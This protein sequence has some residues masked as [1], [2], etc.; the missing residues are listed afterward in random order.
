MHTWSIIISVLALSAAT[1]AY[2]ASNRFDQPTTVVAR[3]Q[4]TG[5]NISPEMVELLKEF[6]GFVASPQ[7]DQMGAATVG[8]GHQCVL[9]GCAEITPPYEFPLNAETG[10]QLLMD[11]LVVCITSGHTQGFSPTSSVSNSTPLP[12]I[13]LIPICSKLTFI[14]SVPSK[15]P[16]HPPPPQ[17]LA[18]L[19][20]ILRTRLLDLQHREPEHGRVYARQA[21]EHRRARRYCYRWRAA[22]MG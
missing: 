7:P 2:P 8:Y 22:A 5:P 6:E 12:P 9:S 10:T 18:E 3:Q 4:C 16:D 11:D 14:L 1:S 13:S 15:R 20:S 19:E 17:R 21:F